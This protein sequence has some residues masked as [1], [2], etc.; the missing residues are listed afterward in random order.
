M[1][2]LSVD[3]TRLVLPNHKTIIEEFGQHGF[4]PKADGLRSLAIGSFLYDPYKYADH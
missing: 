1:R 2:I 3:D 4:G